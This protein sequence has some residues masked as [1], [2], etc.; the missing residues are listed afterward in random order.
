MIELGGPVEPSL[1]VM[2]MN[3]TLHRGGKLQLVKGKKGG[4]ILLWNGENLLDRIEASKER[5]KK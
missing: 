1:Y 4:Y 2:P 5:K 3:V